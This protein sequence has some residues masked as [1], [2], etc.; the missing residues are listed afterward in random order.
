MKTQRR[1]LYIL[2]LLLITFVVVCL[3]MFQN[4][5]NL[6]NEGYLAS[7][8]SAA[9]NFAVL[10]AANTKLTDEQVEALKNSTYEELMTSPENRQLASMMSNESFSRKVDYA[11]IMVLLPDDQVKYAVTEGNADR[12]DA[13]VG[14]PLNIMWLL[15]VNVGDS[16]SDQT[17]AVDELSRYSYWIDQDEQIFNNSP[18]Y[19]FNSSEWGDHLCGYAPIYT[20]EGSY[21]GVMG[22]ELQTTDYDTFCVQA[23][24]ALEVLMFASLAML[25]VLFAWIYRG[26]RRVQF[27]L[28]Y[29]DSLVRV[30]NRG[31]YDKLFVKRMNARRH[32]SMFALMIADADYFKKINDTFGHG[33][34]DAVL[35]ELGEIL[36][37]TFGK[38]HVIRLGGEE[39][40]IG[41]WVRD[42]E[43]LTKRLDSLYERIAAHRFTDRGIT[44][45][46]SAGCVYG[47]SDGLDKETVSDMLR[48]A[49]GVLYEAKEQ[50][51]NRYFVV[52][53]EKRKNN[54]DGARSDRESRE[55]AAGVP[56]NTTNGNDT[57]EHLDSTSTGGG[58]SNADEENHSHHR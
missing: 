5:K 34:G 44:L 3:V 50:G 57:N 48:A 21:I 23:V 24:R 1:F 16:S 2:L 43:E 27:D 17:G 58:V 54:D 26:H 6:I 4:S 32:T 13:P 33:I 55:G 22:V 25:M 36:V 52:P 37:A 18:T 42:E 10:T 47:K 9:E 29:L 8:G 38:E 15:D 31:Y 46:I 40:V 19:L 41:I 30:Y 20:V 11:Y 51:R 28:I 35:V 14:T 12:F 56:M 49:D 7:E 39:F 45:G 53:Y